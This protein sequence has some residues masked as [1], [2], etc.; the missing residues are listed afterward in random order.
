MGGSVSRKVPSSDYWVQITCFVPAI[1]WKPWKC[2]TNAGS[3]NVGALG[4]LNGSCGTQDGT[5]APRR[6]W[7]PT[8]PLLHLSQSR[9]LKG[10]GLQPELVC[11]YNFI[12]IAQSLGPEPEAGWLTVPR[13]GA[14][15]Y[16][17]FL[18]EEAGSG[19]KVRLKY[20]MGKFHMYGFSCIKNGCGSMIELWLWA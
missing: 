9:S 13:W 11:G 7:E 2:L 20:K 5:A 4:A 17:F 19:F 18:S 15:Y 14:S 6:A 8:P 16:C 3:P 12:R 1:W 10:S